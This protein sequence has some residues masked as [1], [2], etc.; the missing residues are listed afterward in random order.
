MKVTLIKTMSGFSPAD[1]DSTEWAS[2]VKLGTAVHADFAKVRNYGFHKKY[3][4]LLN[5]AYDN[6]NPGE[7]DDKYGVPE[8]NFNQ[9]REDLTILCGYYIM[10]PRVDGSLRPKAKS[11]SFGSMEAEDFEK[12]YSTTIDVLLKRIYNSEIDKEELQNIV[13][14]YMSFA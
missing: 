13:D 2:K 11:I 4:A 10:V 5:V 1:P 3:F 9:F 6:W 8:K 12:L 14:S 7:L